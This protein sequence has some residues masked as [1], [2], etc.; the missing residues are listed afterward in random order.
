MKG[1][2][3]T[4]IVLKHIEFDTELRNVGGRAHIPTTYNLSRMHIT[5]RMRGSRVE[6]VV[7]NTINHDRCVVSYADPY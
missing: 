1:Q 4:L 6:Y 5:L 3:S 2:G 7:N